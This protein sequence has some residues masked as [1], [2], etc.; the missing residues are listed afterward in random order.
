MH[1]R[2]MPDEKDIAFEGEVEKPQK[3]VYRK[4][5]SRKIQV[6]LTSS[7]EEAQDAKFKILSATL[8][9]GSPADVDYDTLKIGDNTLSYTPKEPGTHALTIK[10]AVEG[11]ENVQILHCPI[12]APLA[13]WKVRGTANATGHLTIHIEDVPEELQGEQW[14]ITNTTF[15]EGLEGRIENMPTRLNHGENNLNISLDQIVLQEEEPHVIFTIQGPDSET[16]TCQIDLTALCVAQLRGDM[17]ELDGSLSDRLLVVSDEHETETEK[18]FTRDE[19]GICHLPEATVTDP[20]VNREKQAEIEERLN[21]MERDLEAYD[22][23][24]HRLEALEVQDPTHPSRQLPM[25]RRGK[26]RLKDAIASLKSAQVQLQQQCTSA[27]MALFK[28]IENE[29]QEAIETLLEDPRLDV[30]GRDENNN[31]LLYTAVRYRNTAVIRQLMALNADP[32]RMPLPRSMPLHT[33]AYKGYTDIVAILLQHGAN[34]NQEDNG[35]ATPLHGAAEMEGD[36]GT[37]MVT[38]LLRNGAYVNQRDNRGHTPLYY[39]TFGGIAPEETVRRL[40]ETISLINE[41]KT[42]STQT[43]LTSALDN[44]P[45]LSIVEMILKKGATVN[46]KNEEGETPLEVAEGVNLGS[47]VVEDDVMKLFSVQ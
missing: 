24:L 38:M 33:A 17:S 42:S 16:R 32:G 5:E 43:I 37:A 25:F 46:G 45:T 9:D 29:E 13:N 18:F 22:R 41:Q 23:D 10:V 14:R 31:M 26:Q 21:L 6:R 44:Y 3:T 8:A 4:G 47:G 34:V 28:M 2:R 40:L 12:E 7:D 19:E 20:R 27:H 39:A 30:D 15:S 36:I 35:G 11:E 1:I